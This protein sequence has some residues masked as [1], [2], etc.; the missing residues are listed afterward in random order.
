MKHT[1]G[2]ERWT[3]PWRLLQVCP[4]VLLP[5]IVAGTAG[6][7]EAVKSHAVEVGISTAGPHV[8]FK[9]ALDAIIAQD[10]TALNYVRS[11]DRE[12]AMREFAG[13]QAAWH[14]LVARFAG[15]P[16]APPHA[17]PLQGDTLT[18]IGARLVAVDIML[19]AGRRDGALQALEA[20]RGDLVALRKVDETAPVMKK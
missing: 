12:N 6:K 16:A 2:T 13:L 11:G 8:D 9:S 15:M 4:L 18:V 5:A 3:L 7:A 1:T 20:L 17:A 10:R 14:A 19:K